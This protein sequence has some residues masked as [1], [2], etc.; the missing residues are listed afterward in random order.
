MGRSRVSKQQDME[1]GK[2]QA[3]RLHE[4]AI[5]TDPTGRRITS[6]VI[7]IVTGNEF[8][9][10]ELSGRDAAFLEAFKE[11]A[12]A[13]AEEGGDIENWR[14]TPTEWSAWVAAYKATRPD[15]K[16]VDRTNLSKMRAA[17]IEAGWVLKT[18]DDR[19]VLA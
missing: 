19:Y 14:Q 1:A 5:G 9:K 12:Q 10:V 16:G 3:F 18:K 8:T 11:A 2:D 4:V 17:V 13:T 6:C 7:R 15:G